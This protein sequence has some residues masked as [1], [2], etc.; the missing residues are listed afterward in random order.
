M[1]GILGCTMW[2]SIY[3]WKRNY[4][5]L[6]RHGVCKIHVKH[7]RALTMGPR[8]HNHGGRWEVKDQPGLCMQLIRR[9]IFG[10]ED[11]FV[12]PPPAQPPP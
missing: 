10:Y 12:L 11:R 9:Y 6:P 5:C 3:L 2:D 4:V 8:I 1:E 7:V